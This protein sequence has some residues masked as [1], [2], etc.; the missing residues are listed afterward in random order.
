MEQ[1]RGKARN[2]APLQARIG[3]GLRGVSDSSEF[4]RVLH[5]NPDSKPAGCRR[6]SGGYPRHAFKWYKSAEIH[7]K[8]R[9][10]LPLW[11][12]IPFIG[13]AMGIYT[14]PK[15]W[16]VISNGVSGK[17]VKLEVPSVATVSQSA[18]TAIT[19]P[20]AVSRIDAVP[21]VP[22]TP[23]TVAVVVAAA[24]IASETKCRCYNEQ[25]IRVEI[26]EEQCRRASSET[27]NFAL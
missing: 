14:L 3:G 17:G 23:F 7:T 20:P 19:R 16:G 8:Q 18:Q 5:R 26:H 24:C 10:K 13:L 11:I 9:F 4:V 21:I 15:A 25:G 2:A 12:W 1:F 6:G 27:I 22:V